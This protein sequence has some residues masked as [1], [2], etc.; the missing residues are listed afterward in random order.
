MTMNLVRNQSSSVAVNEVDFNPAG[1]D[2]I[3]NPNNR[4][5]LHVTFEPTPVIGYLEQIIL[6]MFLLTQNITNIYDRYI[7][8]LA[9]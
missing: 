5:L 4:Q 1:E 7:K 3:Y 6:A 2:T 8:T 9:R